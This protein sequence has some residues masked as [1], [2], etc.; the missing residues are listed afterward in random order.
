MMHKPFATAAILTAAAL[1]LA[2]SSSAADD[3]KEKTISPVSNP[4]FF[5]DPQINS[6]VR[7]I[8]AYHAIDDKFIGGHANYYAL[9][10]RYAVTDRLAIIATKDGYIQLRSK[11]LPNKDGWAD[12]G[13]GLKYA[14]VDD[15]EHQFILTPGLKI[16]V[17][18]GNERV[19]QGNGSGEWDLFLSSSK[20]FGDFHLTGS[21]GVRLPNDW[22]AE[23]ASAHYSLQLDRYFCQYF[24][25]FVG[26]NGHTVMSEGKAQPFHIEGFDLINFGSQHAEGFTQIVFSTGLRSRLV[27][28][29][30]V[31]FSYETSVTRPEGLFDHRYTFDL[32][33][34]F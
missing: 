7:P 28:N 31:G 9:Q 15:K 30:D 26:F 2:T 3:W 6:E 13:G 1:N 20:G 23:T 5:E 14:L 21:G 29:V 25:P 33:W 24:I 17:P 4:L 18:S 8:F 34:R 22:D 12:I 27:K 16:E 19:F 11:A 10:L 32:I